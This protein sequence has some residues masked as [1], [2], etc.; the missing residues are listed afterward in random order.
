MP[1]LPSQVHSNLEL[2]QGIEFLWDKVIEKKEERDKK[3][4]SSILSSFSS[5]CGEAYAP[6]FH[7]KKIFSH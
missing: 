2:F 7:F 5:K 1:V 4:V 3:S 6:I